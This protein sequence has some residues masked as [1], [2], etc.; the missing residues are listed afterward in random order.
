M[1]KNYRYSI[2]RKIVYISISQYQVRIRA[3]K[4]NIVTNN[5]LERGDYHPIIYVIMNHF[6]HIF[7]KLNSTGVHGTAVI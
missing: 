3:T 6:M 2:D 7:F 4:N 5:I 1:F